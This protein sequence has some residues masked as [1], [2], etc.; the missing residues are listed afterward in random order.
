MKSDNLTLARRCRRGRPP[1]HPSATFGPVA[2]QTAAERQDRTHGRR[3]QAGPANYRL[4]RTGLATMQQGA[5]GRQRGFPLGG[6]HPSRPGADLARARALL[7]D[8]S[9]RGLGGSGIR[10]RCGCEK[11]AARLQ[12]RRPVEAVSP[13]SQRAGLAALGPSA[14]ARRRKAIGFHAHS[15][16]WAS[17]RTLVDRSASPR[18]APR[19]SRAR[20]GDAARRQA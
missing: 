10:R 16:C 17:G 4:R 9:L 15:A 7:M 14:S 11:F 8:A 19:V 18:Q 5:R 6:Q 20:A 13:Q 2:N 12:T 3:R 1:H